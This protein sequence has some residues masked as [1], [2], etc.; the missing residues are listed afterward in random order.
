MTVKTHKTAT[1]APAK[2]TL[3]EGHKTRLDN[4]VH[5]LRPI[6]DPFD[7]VDSLLALPP[8]GK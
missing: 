7:R 4:Y 1:M 2:L 8:E 5:I 6:C 3:P